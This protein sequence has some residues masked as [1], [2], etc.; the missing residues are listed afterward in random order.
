MWQREKVSRVQEVV[1]AANLLEEEEKKK[2]QLSLC[3]NLDLPFL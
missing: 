1:D 3:F 2:S